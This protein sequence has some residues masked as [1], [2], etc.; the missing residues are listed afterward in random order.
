MDELLQ[1]YADKLQEIYEK[2]TAGDHTFVGVLVEYEREKRILND[3]EHE[4]VCKIY[5]HDLAVRS[6][7]E[8]KAPI[9]S[10]R[11]KSRYQGMY[12]VNRD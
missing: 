11:F 3:V 9:T 1:K 8:C 2:R 10:T 4:P 12:S 5:G 6:G 7:F